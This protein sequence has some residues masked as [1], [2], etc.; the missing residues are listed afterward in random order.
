MVQ[1]LG[2]DLHEATI[3]DGTE[4]TQLE[5][6]FPTLQDQSK[7]WCLNIQQHRAFLLMGASLLQHLYTS[8]ELSDFETNQDLVAKIHKINAYI[9]ALLPHDKQLVLFLAGSGGTGKSRVIKCFTDFARRWHSTASNVITASSGVAATLIQ[10]S[11]LHT[12]L[13]IGI[14][15]S[16]SFRPT[17]EHKAAWSEVAVLFVDEFSMISGQLF[18]IMDDRLR[19]LKEQPDRSFGGVNMI[20]C[21]DFYQLPPVKSGPIYPHRND[22]KKIP[23]LK[24]VNGRER[25]AKCLTDVIELKQNHRQQD[26]EWATALE[27][28]RINQPTKADIELVSKRYMYTPGNFLTPPPSTLT[29]VPDNKMR[30]KG[31]HYCEQKVIESLPCL[32][33]ENNWRERGILLIKARIDP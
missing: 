10:G 25:W 13:G 17:M 1:A 30:E 23:S 22:P 19:L 16:K 26:P 11:T 4:P 20:F 15:D 32:I 2:N 31:L 5:A 33:N 18:D 14:D 21:G 12:A 24:T 28:F 7:H 3:T 9:T 6:N 8:N 29:A 27:H